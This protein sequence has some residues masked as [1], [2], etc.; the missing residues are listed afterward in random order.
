MGAKK[1]KIKVVALFGKAGSGKDT[2]LKEVVA[3]GGFHEIVSCTTRPMR[4]GE[5][6]GVDYHF[7]TNE[8]FTDL[9]L[10][11]R[12]LEATVFRDWC[13]GTSL[14]ELK[15]DQINIGV[16]NPE[17]LELLIEHPS[18]DVLPIYIV[19]DDK[20]RLLRQLMR[21]TNPDCAEIVRRYGTDEQDFKWINNRFPEHIEVQN[22]TGA[23][24]DETVEQVLAAIS[25]W[26]K[27]DKE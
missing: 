27:N 21:E 1:M 19:A 20:I 14:D 9:V 13:Y 8:K 17:G 3:N 10:D 12:M 6:D 15:Y 22:G 23:L 16:W 18:I 4:E 5:Q 2:I 26:T 24:L 7:I 25:V 11:N